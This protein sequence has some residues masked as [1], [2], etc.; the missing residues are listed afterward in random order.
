MSTAPVRSSRRY[1][2]WTGALAAL[3]VCLAVFVWQR[4]TGAPDSAKPVIRVGWPT[5]W[6]TQGQLVQAL[7]TSGVLE[8]NGIR[9]NFISFVSGPPAME[10]AKAGSLDVVSAAAQ[11]IL[12]LVAQS[13]D[14]VIVSRNA[15]VRVAVLVPNESTAQSI[16][17]LQG[18]KIGLP[19][20]TIAE[21]FVLSEFSRAGYEVT[22]QTII[23]VDIESLR[24]PGGIN[25]GELQA[26]SAWEPTVALLEATRGART[27]AE[28]NDLTLTAMSRSFI[29]KHPMEAV[30]YMRATRQ[31]WA[32]YASHRAQMNEEYKRATQMQI[33][34]AVLEAAAKSEPNASVKSELEVDIGITIEIEQKLQRTLDLLV[35]RK[36]IAAAPPIGELLNRE[37]LA[38]ASK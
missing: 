28:T 26:V 18:K 13:K 10:A 3:A 4:N 17:D 33:E 7:R 20:G 15:N 11:P 37:V 1:V 36:R 29:E 22:P 5:T 35:K 2:L 21:N 23:N 9:A 6:A 19:V 12:Q 25:W 30:G 31:A 16:K 8:A 27:I 14:W 38:Q 34:S 24:S 32:Y